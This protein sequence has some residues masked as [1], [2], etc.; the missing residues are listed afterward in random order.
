MERKRGEGVC[1]I[2]LQLVDHDTWAGEVAGG[3]EGTES[4]PILESKGWSYLISF[5]FS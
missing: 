5:P 4:W 1:D 2:G 3:M